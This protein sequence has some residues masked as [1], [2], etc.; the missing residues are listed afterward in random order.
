MLKSRRCPQILVKTGIAFWGDE[1]E[2]KRHSA[3]VLTV[4]G[5][6]NLAGYNTWVLQLQETKAFRTVRKTC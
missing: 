4:Q 5:K 2:K 1:L 3:Q 6:N